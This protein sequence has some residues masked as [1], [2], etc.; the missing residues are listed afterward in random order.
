MKR[1]FFSPSV[2]RKLRRVPFEERFLADPCT[3]MCS[4]HTHVLV[5]SK[6]NEMGKI[7]GQDG[8]GLTLDDALLLAMPLPHLLAPHIGFLLDLLHAFEHNQLLFCCIRL[9]KRIALFF[10]L[11]RCIV[12]PLP[13]CVN[14]M[15]RF[16]SHLSISYRRASKTKSVTDLRVII[17]MPSRESEENVAPLCFNGLLL[18]FASGYIHIDTPGPV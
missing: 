3:F 15:T 18:G 9:K 8:K 7:S 2:L 1:Q 11:P 13:S 12:H 10:G 4:D 14:A 5:G 16:P 17:L 6:E